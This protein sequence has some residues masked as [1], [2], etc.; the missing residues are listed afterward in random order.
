MQMIAVEEGLTNVRQALRDAGYQ[1]TD[2]D[3]GNIGQAQ[4]V[5]ISGVDN[6]IMQQ[7][8]IITKVPVIDATAYSADGVVQEVRRRL[9]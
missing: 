3:S 2:L 9:R 8:D 5:V 6:N 1:V 7:E 4:A